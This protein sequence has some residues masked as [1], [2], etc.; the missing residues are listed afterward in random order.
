[1]AKGKGGFKPG[2]KSMAP[3]FQKGGKGGK[4]GKK[5]FSGGLLSPMKGRPF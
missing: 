4:P 2:G 1:M 5:S 3:P